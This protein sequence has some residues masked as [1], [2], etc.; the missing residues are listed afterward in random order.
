[1]TTDG[2]KVV[3]IPA[4]KLSLAAAVRIR[5]PDLEVTDEGDGR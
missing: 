1:V 4:Y 2:S 3:S 5:D